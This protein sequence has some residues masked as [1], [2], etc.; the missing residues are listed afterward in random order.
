M[1]EPRTSRLRWSA[2]GFVVLLAAPGSARL[3]WDGLPFTR[4][5]EVVVLAVLVAVLSHRDTRDALR[6]RLAGRTRVVNAALVALVAA[7][8]LS[9]AAVPFNGGFESCYRGIWAA[10]PGEVCEA[11]W[12]HPWR[13]NIEEQ[14][15]IGALT[16]IDEVIDFGGPPDRLDAFEGGYAS[17]WNLPFANEYPRYQAT[18]LD[19]LPF[20]VRH[21]GVVELDRRSVVPVEYLGEFT[22]AAPYTFSASSTELRSVIFVPLPAGRHSL[23]TS[24]TFRDDV[25]TTEVP[26]VEP[27]PRG[28]YARL[29]VGEPIAHSTSR[30]QLV[31]RG[32]AADRLAHSPVIEWTA[33]FRDSSGRRVAT[34]SEVIDRPDVARA[35]LVDEWRRS[36]FDFA[37]DLPPLAHRHPTYHLEARLADGRVVAVATMTAQTRPDAPWEGPLVTPAPN[38]TMRTDIRARYQFEQPG[39]PLSAVA[40][41]RPDRTWSAVVAAVNIGQFA[42][43]A[44]LGIIA[45]GGVWRRRRSAATSMLIIASTLLAAPVVSRLTFLDP[46]ASRAIAGGVV[47]AVAARRFVASRGLLATALGTALMFGPVIDVYRRYT[48]LSSHPWWGMQI[49]RDRVADWL[50]FQGYARS[51]FLE[52]SLRAGENVFYFM[53]GMRYVTFVMHLIFGE[54]DVLIGVVTGVA[55]VASGLW[56]TLR[57]VA[58]VD[59]AKGWWTLLGA[60]AVIAGVGRPISRELAAAGASEIVAWSLIFLCCVVFLRRR[61]DGPA[62]LAAPIGLAAAGLLR[63]NLSVA[64]TVIAAALVLARVSQPSADRSRSADAG[65]V[66]VAFL[67][68][69]SLGL[70]H[71]LW[72]GQQAIVFTM[73]ADPRQSDFP[74]GDI[75]KVPFDDELRSIAWSKIELLLHLRGALDDSGVFASR[76]AVVLWLSAV[77]VI[78]RQRTKSTT[79]LLLLASPLAYVVSTFPFGI[80]DTP[81]RQ[82]ASLTVLLIAT[83]LAAIGHSHSRRLPA[84]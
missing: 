8:L 51:I 34:T 9:F 71:N 80:M 47:L 5:G 2:A 59:G 12:N 50:V 15:G 36:G 64:L 33:W 17:N 38:P 28:P 29:H 48:N 82:I 3:W 49:F 23:Q 83:S 70:L 79:A 76:V 18:W 54:N 63:P 77:V 57:S 55:V 7:K 16:R 6:N 39:N 43:V 14:L 74:P 66:I 62:W 32:W 10:R 45:L 31:M 58:R 40:F 21:A 4:V 22:M 69:G 1:R 67:G 60:T 73:R 75:W 27:A 13:R 24:L 68:F 37:I 78:L 72:Y 41:E 52:S 42:G 11:S 44:G 84:G 46:A 35:F 61:P 53:P 25:D 81:E 20:T 26:D 65:S 19:R 30:M 56:L